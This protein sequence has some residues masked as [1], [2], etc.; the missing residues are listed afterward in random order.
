MLSGSVAGEPV[1]EPSGAASALFREGLVGAG[2]VE[3]PSSSVSEI[4]GGSPRP[5]AGGGVCP[6]TSADDGPVLTGV[7]RCD[8]V[9]RGPD[10]APPWP[11]R[12]TTVSAGAMGEVS[13]GEAGFD[14]ERPTGRL[15]DWPYRWRP[16]PDGSPCR[17]R[18]LWVSMC[19]WRSCRLGCSRSWS[20]GRCS[21]G[22]IASHVLASIRV[23]C[24][25]ASAGHAGEECGRPHS[26]HSAASPSGLPGQCRP[27][28]SGP[29]RRTTDRNTQA[30][31]MAS[32]A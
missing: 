27:T 1:N 18:F 7:V 26:R 25:I 13:Y 16:S 15:A 24:W 6:V 14:A 29:A 28:G 5:A 4:S 11:Q 19:S 22:R 17:H 9:A 2:G 23:G 3:P 32:S 30:T 20:P 12:S 21:T 10:V 8:P 31:T